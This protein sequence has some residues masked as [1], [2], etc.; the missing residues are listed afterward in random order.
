[1]HLSELILTAYDLRGYLAEAF[2]AIRAAIYRGN[3]SPARDLL[4]LHDESIYDEYALSE[5]LVETDYSW[6]FTSD[7]ENADELDE[8]SVL[9]GLTYPLILI[10][11]QPDVFRMVI[12]G[13]ALSDA[14]PMLGNG[15]IVQDGFR[16]GLRA[17][18]EI[19]GVITPESVRALRDYCNAAIAD[20][21]RSM[22]APLLERLSKGLTRVVDRGFGLV[23]E[24]E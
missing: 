12:G 9:V 1:V 24:R 17:M 19:T 11:H 23:L 2:P 10:Y 6:I 4:A 7:A 8:E 3:L 20:P 14:I 5:A 13:T 22:H 18:W 21:A 16:E 15:E